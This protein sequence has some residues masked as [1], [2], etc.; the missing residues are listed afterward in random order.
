MKCEDREA[1]L[2]E[3]ERLLNE[4]LRRYELPMVSGDLRKALQGVIE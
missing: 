4:I 1:E 2:S 3:K